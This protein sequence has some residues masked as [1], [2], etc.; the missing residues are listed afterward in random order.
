M[1]HKTIKKSIKIITIIFC[2]VFVYLASGKVDFFNLITNLTK[3]NTN[4]TYN[5]KNGENRNPKAIVLIEFGMIF[6]TQLSYSTDR[7]FKF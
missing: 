7:S 3:T 2:F 6:T 1:N 4:S 5:P